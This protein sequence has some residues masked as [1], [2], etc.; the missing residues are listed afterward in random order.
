VNKV[1]APPSLGSSEFWELYDQ[2][3][4]RDEFAKLLESKEQE[5]PL[6]NRMQ[7]ITREGHDL[8]VRLPRPGK[9]WTMP[10]AWMALRNEMVYDEKSQPVFTVQIGDVMTREFGWDRDVFVTQ[11]PITEHICGLF[12]SQNWITATKGLFLPLYTKQTI[13]LAIQLRLE[14]NT[15]ESLEK[16]EKESYEWNWPLV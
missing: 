16:A 3:C 5:T 1:T 13:T 4:T 15:K 7:Q 12:L 11:A 9:G 14:R 10:C 2:F 6:S 8:I